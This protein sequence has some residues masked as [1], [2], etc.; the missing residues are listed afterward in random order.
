[1]LLDF[2]F[3]SF[4]C[5]VFIFHGFSHVLWVW[6]KEYSTRFVLFFSV[7]GEWLRFAHEKVNVL[8]AVQQLTIFYLFN[9]LRY[10]CVCV[11]ERIVMRSLSLR[12]QVFCCAIV[13]N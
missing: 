6:I 1:M 5:K 2:F 11:C 7:L 10:A 9:S 12:I 3:F 4:I 13:Q 8:Y